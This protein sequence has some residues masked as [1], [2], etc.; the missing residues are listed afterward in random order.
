MRAFPSIRAVASELRRIN[1]YDAGARE[2]GDTLIDVR[3]Q[4]YVDGA[5]AVRWGLSDYDQDHS[6]FWGASCVPGDSRR[7]DSEAVARDLLDQAKDQQAC[8][9]EVA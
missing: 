2:D 3:L 9:R 5:W 4:V 1:A 6:G 7:F 8:E